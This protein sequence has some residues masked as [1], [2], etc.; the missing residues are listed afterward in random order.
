MG[1]EHSFNRPWDETHYREEWAGGRRRRGAWGKPVNRGGNRQLLHKFSN[2]IHRTSSTPISVPLSS[3]QTSGPPSAISEKIPHISC[4]PTGKISCTAPSKGRVASCN[5]LSAVDA[6][7]N[8]LQGGVGGRQSKC[9]EEEE[10]C[11]ALLHSLHLLHFELPFM[12]SLH[13]AGQV[14]TLHL[15]RS[16][17]HNSIHSTFKS[18]LHLPSPLQLHQ[19][20]WWILNQKLLHCWHEK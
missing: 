10:S 5:L 14:A 2:T 8:A 3:F 15:I 19:L 6:H 17:I 12:S 9:G 16:I 18:T 11:N 20:M 7:C 13:Q 4:S 1:W